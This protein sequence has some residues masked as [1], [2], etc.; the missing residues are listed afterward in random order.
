MAFSGGGRPLRG[1]SFCKRN[2]P[3]PPHASLAFGPARRLGSGGVFAAVLSAA[4]L[5]MGLKRSLCGRMIGMHTV[6]LFTSDTCGP[7]YI[8]MFYSNRLSRDETR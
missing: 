2:T 3:L 6:R 4:V 5:A 7:F 1:Y 8:D